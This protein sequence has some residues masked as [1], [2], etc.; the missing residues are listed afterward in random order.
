[1]ASVNETAMYALADA[2]GMVLEIGA[3]NAIQGSKV[4]TLT[5][6]DVPVE[7]NSRIVSSLHLTGGE[8]AMI[9]RIKGNLSVLFTRDKNRLV[10]AML[11]N[12]SHMGK[13]DGWLEASAADSTLDGIVTQLGKA[14]VTTF[15]HQNKIW[16]KI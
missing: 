6:G 4:R 3:K 11:L 16:Q 15:R 8:V 10:S 7:F 9:M 2:C 13:P 12:L 5:F 14:I 1:M